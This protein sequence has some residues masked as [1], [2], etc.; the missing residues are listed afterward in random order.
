MKVKRIYNI[1][2]SPC[3][4]T[5][6]VVTTLSSNI[7]EDFALREVESFNCDFTLPEKR[8]TFPRLN[9]DDLV[10]FG[11]PTYA[12]RLPNLLLPYLNT[13][14]GNG[15]LAVCVVTFGNRNFDNSLAELCALLADRGFLV[16]GAGAF[17]AF[18]VFSDSLGKGR[19]DAKDLEEIRD[20]STQLSSKYNLISRGISAR[21]LQVSQFEAQKNG[22]FYPHFS[23]FGA[24]DG[25]YYRPQDSHGN[26]IDIRKVKPLTTS[27]CT[28]CGLCA[29]LCP[30]GSIDKNDYSLV[31]GICVKCCACV[32][33]CPQ[34]AKYFDDPGF[35]Y[36]K[37]DLE[38]KYA[39]RAPNSV[40]L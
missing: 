15:A 8:S 17:S 19:P 7:K 6:T 2:F 3:G 26:F 1:F 39:Q 33:M 34:D 28:S 22:Y 25:P 38:K 36:H 13:I 18:H 23:V 5:K 21:D 31:S 37:S 20:F 4:G 14:E 9:S 11:C 32:R 35:L 12:G 30:M 10:V 24:P 40:F 27:Q 16:F 29:L